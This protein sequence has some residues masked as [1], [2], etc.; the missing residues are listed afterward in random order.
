MP[1]G[2][3][4]QAIVQRRQE[5]ERMAREMRAQAARLDAAPP[6]ASCPEQEFATD[7]RRALVSQSY[8]F[9]QL[10][11][12]EAVRLTFVEEEIRE[13]AEASASARAWWMDCFV[14]WTI[15]VLIWAA[16]VLVGTALMGRSLNVPLP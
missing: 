14:V 5:S 13:K 6:P 1:D 12:S 9:G 7:I 15:R 8:G 10:L 11:D 4:L 2:N 3:G 16:A